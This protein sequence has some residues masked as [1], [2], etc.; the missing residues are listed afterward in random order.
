MDLDGDTSSTF[1]NLGVWIEVDPHDHQCSMPC[2]CYKHADSAWIN[3]ATKQCTDREMI[4]S[5]H[6]KL[7]KILS[8]GAN[9]C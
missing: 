1:A 6:S 5:N 8:R 9:S 3:E 2:E 4:L 7:L